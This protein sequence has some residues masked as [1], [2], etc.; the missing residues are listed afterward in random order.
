[1]KK[2]FYR[3]SSGSS[4]AKLFSIPMQARLE[5]GRRDMFPKSSVFAV[6][7]LAAFVS[8][9]TLLFP[10][11]AH[12][13]CI[14]D[15]D[16]GSDEL[17]NP[18]ENSPGFSIIYCFDQ[19]CVAGLKDSNGNLIFSGDIP[20]ASVTQDGPNSQNTCTNDVNVT[21]TGN[22]VAVLRDSKGI[23]HPE[24]AAEAQFQVIVQ[25]VQCSGTFPTSSILTRVIGVNESPG[26]VFGTSFIKILKTP[27]LNAGNSSLTTLGWNLG[28]C[29]TNTD[30]T[31]TA[32]CSFPFGMVQFK[33]SAA[34]AKELP[35]TGSL[36]TDFL[37]GEVYRGVGSVHF[38]GLRMCKGD[39]NGSASTVACS[40]GG[41]I[42]NAV[43]PFGGDWNAKFNSGSASSQYDIIDADHFDSILP[44]TV[45][46]T[47]VDNGGIP[48]TPSISA[49]SCFLQTSKTALRCNF[50]ARAFGFTCTSGQPVNV[51]VRGQ[52]SLNVGGL[53][54]VQKFKSGD[55]PTCS[56]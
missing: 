27:V 39:A 19:P 17:N 16:L 5:E 7:A 53:E 14:W 15:C 18:G 20:T 6:V 34:R 47:I 49:G 25:H 44:E 35:D 30:G 56:Q 43:W 2:L 31:L 12:A 26:N 41:V 55:S 13:Q 54:T 23:I 1:M 51:E 3:L 10:Q 21:I 37:E 40:A 50:D 9:G 36:V 32:N 11:V 22:V 52:F 46:A 28:G 4:F 24:S 38:V 42:A 29:P 8:L 33:S 48:I 45:T